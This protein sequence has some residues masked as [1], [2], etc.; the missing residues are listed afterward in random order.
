MLA[1]HQTRL[2]QN[3]KQMWVAFVTTSVVVQPTSLLF[4]H[5]TDKVFQAIITKDLDVTD[6][7]T[8]T[9]LTITSEEANALRCV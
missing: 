4:Q 8:N 7:S 1:F 6:K 9:F 2:S 3:F 5:I